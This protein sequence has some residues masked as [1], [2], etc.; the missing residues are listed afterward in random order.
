MRSL[1][2]VV[3]LS[4]C[5]LMAVSYAY[6]GSGKDRGP[7][8]SVRDGNGQINKTI[9]SRPN[10]ADANGDGICDNA[11]SGYGRGMGYGAVKGGRGRGL[12]RGMRAGGFGKG[13]RDGSGLINRTGVARPNYVDTDG[14]GICDNSGVRIPTK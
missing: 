8:K 6:A 1:I 11:G 12:G 9:P 13:V 14:D 3:I 4:L 10:Y 2:K 5:M 7:G